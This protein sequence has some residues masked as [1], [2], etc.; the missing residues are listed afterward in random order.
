MDYQKIKTNLD[1]D[2]LI[3]NVAMLKE[4]EIELLKEMGWYYISLCEIVPPGISE[5][6]DL[7]Y[8]D[9]ALMKAINDEMLEEIITFIKLSLMKDKDCLGFIGADNNIEIC[10]LSKKVCTDKFQYYL[11]KAI[12]K[13][14]GNIGNNS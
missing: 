5:E 4:K 2:K 7:L 14:A 10:F 6:F 8:C 13:F 1:G 3:I 12:S 11:S 9:N